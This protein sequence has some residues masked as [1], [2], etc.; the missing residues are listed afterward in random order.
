MG[1]TTDHCVT[2]LEKVAVDNGW[3]VGIIV[4][5]AVFVEEKIDEQNGTAETDNSQDG[6]ELVTEPPTTTRPAPRTQELHQ[7]R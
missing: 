5:D 3:T 6:L 2:L 7:M 4:A 1:A